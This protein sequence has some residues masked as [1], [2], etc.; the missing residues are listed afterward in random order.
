[1]DADEGTWIPWYPVIDAA[2]CKACRQCLGFCL[3]GVYTEA[4]GRVAVAHPQRCKTN[5]PACARICPEAALIFP[6]CGEPPIDGSEI[7]EEDVSRR[8][9]RAGIDELL[10]DDARAALAARRHRARQSLVDRR[11]IAQALAERDG[12][13]REQQ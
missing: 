13:A 7:R 12:H 10:G 8:R 5:C 1:M 9:G 11:R 4:A 6:K 3:F 2:R